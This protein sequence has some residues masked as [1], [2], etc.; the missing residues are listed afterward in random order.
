MKFL[1]QAPP[2]HPG[3]GPPRACPT[4]QHTGHTVLL[5]ADSGGAPGVHRWIDGRKGPAGNDL[6][7]PPPHL[8]LQLPSLS[9]REVAVSLRSQDPT[10]L[11]LSSP[12]AHTPSLSNGL[13]HLQASVCR[14]IPRGAAVGC[15]GG[16]RR[17]PGMR[18]HTEPPPA[19]LTMVTLSPPGTG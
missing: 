7:P 15:A 17:G 19:A 5:Q 16:Q 13:H 12:L 2:A 8:R 18:A 11:G 10:A 14:S 4:S 3:S 6:P 9:V 1:G